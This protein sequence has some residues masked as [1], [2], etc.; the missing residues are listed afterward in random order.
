QKSYTGRKPIISSSV[1]DTLCAELGV[2]GILEKLNIVLGTSY[3]LEM[4][5][6]CSLLESYIIEDYD[7]VTAFSYLRPFWYNDLTDIENTLQTREAWDREMRQDVLV[8]N[9]IVS[10]LLPPRCIWDL[11][12]NRVAPWWV[13]RKY[14][15]AISHAW[16]KEEDRVDTRTPINGYEWPVPMP[17]DAN[18]DLIRIEMLNEGAE[19]AWLD[20]VLC[21]RQVGGRREDLRLEEWKL[22]VPTIGLVYDMAYDQL[23]CYLSGLGRPFSLKKDDLESDTCWFRRAW[24]LQETEH[25]M[26]IGGDTGD[27][28]IMEKEMQTRVENQLSLLKQ[29]ISALGMPVFIALSEMR[30]RVSTNP[31]DRVAGLSYLL[32]TDGIPAYYAT[33]SEEDAWSALV[34][35][36]VITYRGHMF[37]LYPQPGNGSKF[38][39]PSW[40]QAMD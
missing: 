34:D 4:R 29:G 40:K 6:L 19:Y 8:N 11:F 37:F 31:V 35:E 27:D 12:S 1:A 26:I 5:S 28:R 30:K 38:W 13:A 2:I 23:V 14:P 33:Q 18:L 32:W 24:T 10:P 20:D 25:Q 7:F 21:L 36:M 17:R 22:D 15:W 39:R 16:M 3:T 9:K